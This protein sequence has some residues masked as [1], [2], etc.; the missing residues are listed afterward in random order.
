MKR[1]LSLL[2]ISFSII[3][4]VWISLALDIHTNDWYVLD[5]TNSLTAEQEE[6]LESKIYQARQSTDIEM[7]ILI[8][9]SL[10]GEDIFNYSFDVAEARWVGDK[11]K[12]NGLFM[13]FAMVDRERRIQVWYGLEW[14]IT[15]GIA[16]R[17]WEKNIST[18]FKKWLY[19]DWIN[20]TIQDIINY[21]NQDPAALEYINA[22]T[23][24]S[25][26]NSSDENSGE[27]FFWAFIALLF[28]M[29]SLVIKYDTK[30]KKNKIKKWWRIALIVIWAVAWLM[31]YMFILPWQIMWS[32][33]AWYG[34]SIIAML[35][36]LIGGKWWNWKWGFFMWW[37]WFSS[38]GWWSFWG[39]GWWGFGWW[40]G[41][42]K[43]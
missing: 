40:G 6:I 24:Y 36:W 21:I 38:W 9:N 8:I 20:S 37:S 4:T 1:F 13:L 34:A 17:F 31:I 12:N 27:R 33:F 19:F 23:N 30:K 26:S 22:S 39:F 18:N 14:I 10:E 11:D 5:Q 28:L 2:L 16:K 7:W 15:D 3:L 42:G 41:G 32:G 25:K 29:K 35:L 43:R